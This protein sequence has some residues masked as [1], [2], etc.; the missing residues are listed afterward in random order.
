M[1]DKINLSEKLGTFSEHW[2]PRTIAQLNDYDVM[3]V[4][5]KA[6]LYGTNMMKP[7]IS[8]WSSKESLISNCVTERLRLDP[9]NYLSYQRASNTVLS[10]MKK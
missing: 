1:N 5:V 3:V 8:F 9:V 2:S 4:K 10:R 6:N 7:M